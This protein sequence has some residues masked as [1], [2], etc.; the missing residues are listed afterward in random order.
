MAQAAVSG[1]DEDEDDPPLPDAFEL[2]PPRQPQQVEAAQMGGSSSFA[3]ESTLREAENLQELILRKVTA[4]PQ[5]RLW[6]T[7]EGPSGIPTPEKG[8]LGHIELRRLNDKPIEDLIRE[9]WGGGEYK[10]YVKGSDGALVPGLSGR[11]EIAGDIVPISVQGRK[12]LRTKQRELEETDG[13]EERGGGKRDAIY[14]LIATLAKPSQDPQSQTVAL[15]SGLMQM[16]DRMRADLEKQREEQRLR[17]REEQKDLQKEREAERK[18]REL[19]RQEEH[20][21]RI[22]EIRARADLEMQEQKERAKTEREMLL[23]NLEMQAGGGLGMDFVKKMKDFV[24][25]IA[26]DKLR[27]QLDGHPE[28][29]A[30]FKDAALKVFEKDGG[31]IAKGLLSLLSHKMGMPAQALPGPSTI[32]AEVGEGEAPAEGAAEPP[33]AP[34]PQAAASASASTQI[35]LAKIAPRVTAF[36]TLLES[37]MKLQ[38]DPEAAWD[39]DQGEEPSLRDLYAELPGPARQAL[40]R[41]W[42]DFARV[43]PPTCQP[44]LGEFAKLCRSEPPARAWLVAFLASPAAPWSADA[45]EEPPAETEAEE[46]SG[47]GQG[48]EEPVDGAPEQEA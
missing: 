11:M 40:A 43:V 30:S 33:A 32:D 38:T 18:Q 8:N 7:R 17:D 45:A 29:P 6:V 22:A 26:V 16:Q 2:P 24:A 37:E 9:Q 42:N 41:G 21:A 23:K 4:D 27:D 5:G 47:E 20:K 15:F 1:F 19:E 48:S 14:D 39:A 12:Y 25:E 31:E 13:D 10:W 36:V 34:Q 28:T 35:A 3:R 44:A 46:A